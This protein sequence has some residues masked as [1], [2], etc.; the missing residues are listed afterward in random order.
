MQ[1]NRHSERKCGNLEILRAKLALQRMV[2]PF[3][4]VDQYESDDFVTDF[5]NVFIQKVLKAS[6]MSIPEMKNAIHDY[7]EVRN[8]LLTTNSRH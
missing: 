8:T 6:S 2:T 4:L 5:A 1:L 3:I 7:A